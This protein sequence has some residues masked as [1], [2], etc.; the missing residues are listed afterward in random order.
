MQRLPIRAADG[1][2]TGRACRS[3]NLVDEP[4]GRDVGGGGVIDWFVVRRCVSDG[5]GDCRGHLQEDDGHGVWIIVCDCARGRNVLP[6]D[7]GTNLTRTGSALRDV[8]AT[9]RSG[10]DLR[11]GSKDFVGGEAG[12]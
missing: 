5:I 4:I 1:E 6:V 9:G 12:R 11:F 3:G 10:W 2:R 7:D 8:G